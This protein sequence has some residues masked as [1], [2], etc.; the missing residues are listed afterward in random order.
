MDMNG[1]SYPILSSIAFHVGS[2][3]AKVENIEKRLSTVE[4]RSRLD[5]APTHW[6]Q[7]GIGIALLTAAVT[8]RVTWGAV[9]PVLSKLG[10]GG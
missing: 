2:L 5:L 7:I 3:S 1:K 6:I 10:S 4:K 9:L 8:G